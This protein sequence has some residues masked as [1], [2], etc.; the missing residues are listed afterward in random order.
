LGGT[1]GNKSLAYPYREKCYICVKFHCLHHIQITKAI[2]CLLTADGLDG[3]NISKLSPLCSLIGL[4]I[5]NEAFKS[6][7]V[8]ARN[9]IFHGE[10]F[11]S[12]KLNSQ[13]PLHY[14][15]KT[16]FPL[17]DILPNVYRMYAASLTFGG[18]SASCEASF[19]SLSRVLTPYR[20][21]MLH[22]RKADLVI[23]SYENKC[24]QALDKMALMKR[25]SQK[26]RRISLF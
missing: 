6:E 24:T 22:S 21:S 26:S 8:V 16:L 10:R 9:L 20:R 17:K 13:F 2:A 11:D 19:S 25:F 18:S 5:N 1:N 23:L 12:Q 7:L 15:T 4:D 14:I 3:K